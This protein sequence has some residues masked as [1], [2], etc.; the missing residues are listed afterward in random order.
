MESEQPYICYCTVIYE[1][2]GRYHCLNKV[3]DHLQGNGIRRPM[4]PGIVH[5]R[6]QETQREVAEGQQL[7]QPQNFINKEPSQLSLGPSPLML[8]FNPTLQK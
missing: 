5:V 2:R 7:M 4:V 1:I 6:D 8:H 3:L